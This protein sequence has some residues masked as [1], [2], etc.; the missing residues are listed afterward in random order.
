[1][2]MRTM[3][4]AVVIALFGAACGGGDDRRAGGDECRGLGVP[5]S[6]AYEFAGRAG[7]IVHVPADYDPGILTPVVLVFHGAMDEPSDIELITGFSELADEEGFLAVYPEGREGA[8]PRAN[9]SD[10]TRGWSLVNTRQGGTLTP[11][12]EKISSWAPWLTEGV[13]DGNP[14]VGYVEGLLG[15]LED[16]FCVDRS[17]VYATGHSMGGG[18]TFALGCTLSDQIAAIGPVSTFAVKDLGD[19]T[20]SRP[21]PVMSFFS[22]DDPGYEG[23][24]WGPYVEQ[25]SFAEFGELWAEVNECASGPEAGEASGSSSS[26]VWAGCSAPVIMWSLSDGGHTWPGST[27]EEFASTD[28]DASVTLWEFFARHE[29]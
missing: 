16:V 3:L 27:S 5:D 8:S 1:M 23:G 2:L 18:F 15:E 4:L 7:T 24:P 29:L 22:I 20:P 12:Q 21:V 14:D 10:S 28:I 6:G 13:I 19:C 26:Q 25:I 9:S 11:V 17:R